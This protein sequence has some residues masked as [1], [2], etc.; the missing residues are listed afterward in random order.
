MGL[1][2]RVA[3]GWRGAPCTLSRRHACRAFHTVGG[4]GMAPTGAGFC[5]HTYSRPSDSARNAAAQRHAAFQH[6]IRLRSS[7]YTGTRLPPTCD[8]AAAAR[9]GEALG[10]CEAPMKHALEAI[11]VRPATGSGAGC[12]DADATVRDERENEKDL[13][14]HSRPV[15]SASV[16]SESRGQRDLRRLHRLAARTASETRQAQFRVEYERAVHI[17]RD[18]RVAVEAIVPPCRGRHGND[19]RG[20]R[21]DWLDSSEAV[22]FERL[23]QLRDTTSRLSTA[24]FLPLPVAT[25]LQFL[26]L[27]GGIVALLQE[28]HTT[29][30]GYVVRQAVR[31]LF[32]DADA[33]PKVSRGG[34]A[35]KAMHA[36]PRL[37]SGLH[38]YKL[39]RS[40]LSLPGTESIEVSDTTGRGMLVEELCVRRLGD[41]VNVSADTSSKPF[42]HEIG[43]MRAVRVVAWCLRQAAFSPAVLHQTKRRSSLPPRGELRIPFGVGK[44]YTQ[45]VLAF[46]AGEDS[47]GDAVS[48]QGEGEGAAKQR[49]LFGAAE[50]ALL[51]SAIVFYEIRTMEAVKVLVEAAPV[52]AAE[53]DALSG[54]QLSCVMLAYAT[55][56]YHGDLAQHP[57]TP[58][59]ATLLSKSTKQTNFYLLLG[60]RAGE[61]GEELHEDDAARVLRALAMVGV[62]HEGL[63]RSL[64]SSMR[65]KGLRRRVLLS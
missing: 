58:L 22:R 16:S 59:H 24:H 63:R 21:K 10:G 12:A 27:I 37:V 38:Y 2:S 53:V 48:S 54:H 15:P 23:H 13:G 19:L 9:D 62:E 29:A 42:L 32:L 44:E 4:G 35:A 33:T 11:D 14:K 64:E 31:A 43:P 41:G 46:F 28:P 3:L 40:V 6:F 47:R 18:I 5:Q 57:P 56:Q 55:L 61:L 20:L 30:H 17:L 1:P 8:P 25:I 39:L 52:C 60:E 50:L 7:E 36:R 49:S 34:A 26:E 51:C 65:M 45:R